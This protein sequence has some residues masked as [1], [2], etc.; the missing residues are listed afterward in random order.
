[1]P[2]TTKHRRTSILVHAVDLALLLI[3]LTI[4][5]AGVSWLT[6]QS[7][8]AA[9]A[10]AG[11]RSRETRCSGVLRSTRPATASCTRAASEPRRTP[12]SCS[13]KWRTPSGAV[14]T[15]TRSNRRRKASQETLASLTAE[16]D[17]LWADAR[18]LASQYKGSQ[19]D[20]QHAEEKCRKL[21]EEL[22][23]RETRLGQ[24][25]R[26]Q[27][28]LEEEK[29]LVDQR[30]EQLADVRRKLEVAASTT[31]KLREETAEE[32]RKPIERE[33]ILVETQP[34]F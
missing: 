28:D 34:R 17:R 12:P 27:R 29:K 33:T 22:R 7:E 8:A 26:Q 9:Q 19:Q 25:D 32:T 2:Q 5:T 31:D 18:D 15:A 13:G 16:L 30:R 23:D 1:M 14:P 24:L 4:A 10:Q 11:R 21:A 20:R 6:T 3:V